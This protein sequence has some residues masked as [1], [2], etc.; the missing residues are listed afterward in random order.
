MTTGGATETAS[1]GTSWP[2]SVFDTGGGDGMTTRGPKVQAPRTATTIG[3]ALRMATLASPCGTGDRGRLFRRPPLRCSALPVGR[4]VERAAL[5]RL[6]ARGL[7]H[8][9]ADRVERRDDLAGGLL[10][11]AARL[12]RHR[13]DA[14][15]ERGDVLAR[16]AERA[17]QPVLLDVQQLR[18]ILA[19]GHLLDRLAHR[20]D[21]LAAAAEPGMRQRV[22][23]GKQFGLRRKPQS[24]VLGERLAQGF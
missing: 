13:C 8:L 24:R 14:V 15:V 18:R 16:P 6:V 9:L 12:L 11:F 5:L 10:E 17:G 7:P 20:I 1:L 4:S 22:D 2:S 3:K 19:V 23:I 21:A